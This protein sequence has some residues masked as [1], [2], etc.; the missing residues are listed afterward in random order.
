MPPLV[1]LFILSL[2]SG[3]VGASADTNRQ[4]G[5]NDSEVALVI[6]IDR[7][8]NL[9]PSD[10]GPDQSLTALGGFIR[11]QVL[12]V[13][14]GNTL[15]VLIGNRKETVRLIGSDAPEPAQSPWGPAAIQALKTLAEGR[16][17]RLELDDARRDQAKRLL[18]YVFIGDTMVNLEMVRLGQ[19]L[20][21]N[22][23]PNA[24]HSEEYKNAE[25]EAR[26]AGRGMWNAAQPLTVSPACF[27]KQQA[28]QPC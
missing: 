20:A 7:P 5:V 3:C 1:I 28:G 11:G 22:R 26:E 9:F 23:P 10:A 12:S 19:A 15:T 14:D 6:P 4:D 13:S 25:R 17:V 18:A 16:A 24:A 2:L 21:S 8:F 27:R